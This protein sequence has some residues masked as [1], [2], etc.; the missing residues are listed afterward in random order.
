MCGSPSLGKP[1]WDRSL[2]GHTVRACIS[3]QSSMHGIWLGPS[4]LHM[5]VPDPTR[6]RHADTRT[7]FETQAYSNTYIQ[8]YTIAKTPVDNQTQP[9]SI[10]KQY[11]Y[12]TTH[13]P[14]ASKTWSALVAPDYPMV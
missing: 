13:L 1:F 10:W 11:F 6:T 4:Q 2:E 8:V 7:S 9:S 14:P 3:H 12:V 5:Q